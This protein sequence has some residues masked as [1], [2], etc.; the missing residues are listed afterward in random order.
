MG[1]L[2]RQTPTRSE[3]GE[4][5]GISR[6]RL[7]CAPNAASHQERAQAG[8]DALWVW[9]VASA[10]EH[11]TSRCPPCVFWVRAITPSANRAVHL[12]AWPSATEA[13]LT[14]ATPPA[15]VVGNFMPV[16]LACYFAG[17]AP[18]SRQSVC[19]KA[20]SAGRVWRTARSGHL[21][22]SA[23]RPV[24]RQRFCRFVCRFQ[25]P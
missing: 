22:R 8:G 5:G 2:K 21:L 12:Q 15:V 6:R 13:Q 14:V 19:A 20:P 10:T 24:R 3:R 7:C 11:T 18:T 1:V 23:T 17:D 9:L 16:G 4:K 25:S